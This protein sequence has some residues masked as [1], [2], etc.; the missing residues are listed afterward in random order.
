MG[1][2]PTVLCTFMGVL[3]SDTGSPVQ[4]IFIRHNT[5]DQVPS[6]LRDEHCSRDQSVG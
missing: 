1:L 6:S 4:R 3:L 5:C 2:Q